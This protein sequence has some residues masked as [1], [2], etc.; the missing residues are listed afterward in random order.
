MGPDWLWVEVDVEFD[1]GLL[2]LGFL[3]AGVAHE[4]AIS[5]N[6]ANTKRNDGFF[7]IFISGLSFDVIVRDILPAHCR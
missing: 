6:M 3:T 7:L 1:P 5:E 4:M 2:E